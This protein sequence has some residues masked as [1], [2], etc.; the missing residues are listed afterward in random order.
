MTFHDSKCLFLWNQLVLWIYCIKLGASIVF[1][2]T[3]CLQHFC[4]ITFRVLFCWSCDIF[5]SLSMHLSVTS[6][7]TAVQLS[8][9]SLQSLPTIIY[10]ASEV[11]I[12]NK[13]TKRWIHSLSRF[14]P[15][16][17]Y[18][19]T[20]QYYVLELPKPKHI[21]HTVYCWIRIAYKFELINRSL[22]LEPFSL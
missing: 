15:V 8:T 12:M 9:H 11:V 19:L 10:S 6:L 20:V 7:I 4:N 3:H 21:A 16:S 13:R 22:T 1:N 14:L 17:F 5:V 2:F 18:R